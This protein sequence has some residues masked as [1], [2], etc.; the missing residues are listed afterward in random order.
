M[1]KVA[2]IPA[3]LNSTRVP[4]KNLLLVD[5]F[6]LVYY[7]VEACKK[8]GAFDEIYINSDAMIFKQIADQLGVKFYHRKESNGGSACTMINNSKDCGGDRCTIHDHFLMDFISNVECDYLVQV[9]TTSPLIKPET[10]LDFTT[11][12]EK[13]DSL[14]TTEQTYSESFVDGKPVNFNVDKK[15]ETQ[16]LSP[17]DSVVG[18]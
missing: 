5:G 15:Q 3:L 10:I 2:L 16:S 9:H 8:S 17:V 14:V 12:L 18:H 11:T 4:N 1:K 7:V 6:P 13:Y